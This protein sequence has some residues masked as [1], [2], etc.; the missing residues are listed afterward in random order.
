MAVLGFGT[1]ALITA[2]VAA[3]LMQDVGIPMTF[4]ILGTS[5]FILMLLGA[6][7]IAP[8][9]RDWL[10]QG[11]KEKTSRGRQKI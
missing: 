11:M 1:G 6:L 4:Y 2:P 9:P 7:Y 10:P 8:P 3:A 5:Y